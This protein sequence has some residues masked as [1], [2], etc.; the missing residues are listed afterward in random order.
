MVWSSLC[1]HRP[2]RR[3]GLNHKL[4]VLDLKLTNL[5]EGAVVRHQHR[6][7]GQD[8]DGTVHLVPGGISWVLPCPA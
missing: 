3:L 4:R 8:I 6:T 5:T 7:Q 2:P 1:D